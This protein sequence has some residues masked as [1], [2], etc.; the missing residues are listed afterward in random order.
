MTKEEAT[1]ILELLYVSYPNFNKH[2]M[3]NFNHIWLERL[4][5]GDYKK[6][7]R[8]TKDYCENNPYPPSFADVFVPIYKPVQTH[9]A[10]MLAEAEKKVAEEMKDPEIRADRERMVKEMM[11]KLKGVN[12]DG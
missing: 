12:A 9:D 8:K 6:T 2:G 10:E 1:E 4:M 3:K 7:L 5:E 11:D